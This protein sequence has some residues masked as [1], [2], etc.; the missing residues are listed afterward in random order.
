[1]HDRLSR[2]DLLRLM[3][4]AGRCLTATSP[5]QIGTII[6]SIH[7]LTSY[8]RAALCA[9][10]ATP[11]EIAL[12][13]VV[14]HSYG[15]KWAELYANQNFQRTDPILIHASTTNGAF[16]WDEVP[17]PASRG[18]SA[19]F[20]EAAADFG[21][22]DG[23]SFSCAG[24]SPPFGSVLSL[25]GVP[26]GELERTRQVLT[27][28]GPHLYETYRRALQP[29]LENGNALAARE[30]ALAARETAL[31]ARGTALVE[32]GTALAAPENTVELSARELEALNWA[33]QGKTYWEIGCILGISERTVKF[34]FAR[35]RSKLDVVSTSHAIAKAMRIGLI[36]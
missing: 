27:A 19:A 30:N 5:E 28:I 14:N 20:L 15:T 33:Q 9:F 34:H 26:A 12:T 21:L 17:P 31:A 7:D 8:S 32:H 6:S 3:D 29:L 2:G 35:I 25:T 24:S 23:I 18:D 4:L 36:T 1:M 11:G 13:H 22:A 10:S 16:R